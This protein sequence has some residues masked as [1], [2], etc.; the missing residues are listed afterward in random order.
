[1]AGAHA[2]AA[3]TL[4]EGRPRS[5]HGGS[6][7]AWCPS[8]AGEAPGSAGSAWE[9]TAVT[10][11]KN[12]TIWSTQEACTRP[13]VDCCPNAACSLG[14]AHRPDEIRFVC[15]H[16]RHGEGGGE[17]AVSPVIMVVSAQRCQLPLADATPRV[18][19]R[20]TNGYAGSNVRP[21]TCRHDSS[22]TVPPML[23]GCLAT[24]PPRR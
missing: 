6:K 15:V 1:M 5:A 14:A 16:R 24:A 17:R 19:R 7:S 13:D 22:K 8:R 20:C 11:L 10:T 3:G 21:A 4:R 9:A 23:G 12:V 18:H 2:R